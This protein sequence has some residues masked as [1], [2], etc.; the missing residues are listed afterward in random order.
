MW[1]E[2][3]FQKG[4]EDVLR[5]GIGAAGDNPDTATHH[6]AGAEGGYERGREF[7]QGLAGEGQVKASCVTV[8]IRDLSQSSRSVGGCRQGEVSGG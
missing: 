8:R 6:A 3:T 1:D 5:R 2:R 4:G 7:R